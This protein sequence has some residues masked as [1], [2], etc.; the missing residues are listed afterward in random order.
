MYTPPINPSPIKEQYDRD[1]KMGVLKRPSPDEDNDWYFREVYSAK[2]NGTPRRSVD[3]RPLNKW[4]KRDA[5]ATVSLSC[6]TTHSRQHMENN[7]RYLEWLS[8]STTAP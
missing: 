6:S 7:H 3:Y 5:F 1:T 4:V 2:A 8:F